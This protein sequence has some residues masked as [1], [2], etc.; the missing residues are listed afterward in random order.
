[1]RLSKVP[2]LGQA[3]LGHGTDDLA[4]A[5]GAIR[6]MSMF[7]FSISAYCAKDFDYNRSMQRRGRRGQQA[8]HVAIDW[9]TC[10]AGDSSGCT[11]VQL[12]SYGRCWAHLSAEELRQAL[13]SL[14]PGKNLDLRGTTLDGKLLRQILSAFR[15]PQAGELLIGDASFQ[16][17]RINSDAPF[18]GAVFNGPARF[19]E[20][21]F[22]GKADFYG[23]KFKD[24]AGFNGAEFSYADFERAEFSGNAI[25]FKHVKFRG[26]AEFGHVTFEGYTEFIGAEFLDSAH[27]SGVQIHW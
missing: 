12:G 10:V 18:G 23:A 24:Y 27:F 2:G 21:K 19:F 11:G 17:S 8:G 22:G 4:G 5:P 25:S 15:D 7:T 20:A 26:A 13:G 3:A 9:P 1:V 14:A 16:N 6:R